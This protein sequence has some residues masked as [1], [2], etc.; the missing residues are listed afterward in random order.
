VLRAP[1]PAASLRALLYYLLLLNTVMLLAGA[2]A[3]QIWH[4]P[5]PGLPSVLISHSLLTAMVFGMAGQKR[6]H[7]S[8]YY[9]LLLLISSALLG[10]FL[11]NSGGHTNPMISLLLLPVAM[12]TAILYWQATVLVAILV[13]ALYALQTHYFVPLTPASAADWPKLMS[14]HLHGMWLTFVLSVA[15][16]VGVIL[17]LLTAVRRQQELLNAQ[18]EQRSKDERLIAMA[19]FAASAVHQLGTPLSTLAVLT[20]DFQD[21]QPE[22]QHDWQLMQQQIQLCK[23]ILQSLLRRTEDL[24]YQQDQLL[25]AEDWLQRLRENFTLLHPHIQ[26]P[27]DSDALPKRYLRTDETLDQ[28]ILNVLDNAIRASQQAPQLQIRS[29]DQ[30]LCLRIIDQ[31]SGISATL[32]QQLGQPFV[33]GR[34]DG[35]GLG[36]FLSH[37]AIN[38]LGGQ[39]SLSPT[40]KGTMT[41][42]ILPWAQHDATSVIN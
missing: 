1:I 11:F 16:L 37:A 4:V 22:H 20:E 35:T 32:R 18:R 9:L 21:L 36:L 3:T 30:Q 39:L 33:S 38:R 15:V 17:P 31:G 19:T 40:E 41:E 34:A 7:N 27:I 10:I 8:G 29:T 12:S 14:L 42:I 28:A 2:W 6:F 24:R 26:L 25:L 13:L 5:I 23:T